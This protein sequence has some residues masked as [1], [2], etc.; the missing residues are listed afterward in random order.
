MT[1]WDGFYSFGVKLLKII[2]LN[3]LWLFFSAIGLFAFGLFPATIALFTIT[4]QFLLDIDKPITRTFWEVYKNEWV[5]GNGYAVISYI[6]V[7]ILAIDFYAIYMFDSLSILLIPTFIIAFIIF[8]TLFFFFPVYVHFD[9]AFL[10]MIKQAFLFTITSPFTVILN[11]LSIVLIYGIFNI[12]PGAIPLFAGSVVSLFVMKF[13]LRSF[14][15]IEQGKV[16]E[17]VT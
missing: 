17:A 1:F 11:T 9:L 5:S 4:R 10:P 2:Y 16:S 3:F 8:G 14:K 6:I 15:K 12:M 13:S 7:L